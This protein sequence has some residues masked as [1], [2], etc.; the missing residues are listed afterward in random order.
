MKRGVCGRSWPALL[1]CLPTGALAGAGWTDYAHVTALTAT[2]QGRF[3]VEMSVPENPSGWR[4]KDGFYRDYGLPGA[5]AMFR[6]LLEAVTSGKKVPVYVTGNCEID[7]Y[8]EISAV[9]IAP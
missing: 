8:A 9:S 4:Y 6:V 5:E 3:L 2:T 7:G 1:L